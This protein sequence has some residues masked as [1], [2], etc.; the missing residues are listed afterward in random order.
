[1]MFFHN[2]YV[3]AFI[4][5]GVVIRP[6]ALASTIAGQAFKVRTHPRVLGRRRVGW[7]ITKRSISVF[8]HQFLL[9]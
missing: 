1:M 4:G 5:F 7:K 9:L 6:I 8:F 3:S 2:R